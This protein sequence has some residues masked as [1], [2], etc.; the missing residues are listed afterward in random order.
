MWPYNSH[1]Q[2]QDAL[3]VGLATQAL[4]HMV[5]FDVYE[6]HQL[7]DALD[8]G[9]ATQA[10]AHMVRFDIYESH[11]AADGDFVIYGRTN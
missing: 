8:V 6:S 10:L 1:H 5:R 2:L 3:D 4:V 11:P 7:Q 9:L